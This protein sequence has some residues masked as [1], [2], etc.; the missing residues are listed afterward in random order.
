MN[1]ARIDSRKL[2]T[3]ASGHSLSLSLLTPVAATT[4]SS[5]MSL[6]EAFGNLKSSH[7]DAATRAETQ[8][9]VE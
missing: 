7:H 3:A 6:H 1:R 8:H 4:V 9:L 5:K 2:D